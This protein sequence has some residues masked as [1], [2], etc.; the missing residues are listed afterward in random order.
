MEH[1]RQLGLGSSLLGFAPF[2]LLLAMIACLPLM[3]ATE[4]WWG[5]NRNKA[6]VAGLCA[7]VGILMYVHPTGDY[8]KLRDTLLEYLTFMALL[9]SLYVVCGGIHI[10]GA[11]AGLPYMNTLFLLVGALLA[12][13]MGTTG[14][15]MI[16]IRPLIRANRLRTRNAHVV[17]FFI[18]IVSNAGGLLTP[19]GD[20]PL[21]LGF[22]RGVP[23]AWTFRLF[24]HWGITL[25]LL[26]TIFHFIDEVIFHREEKDTKHF[27]VEEISKAERKVYVEGW[28][29]IFFLLALLG[30]IMA[31]GYLIQPTFSRL[32]GAEVG[33]A[34]SEIFQILAMIGIALMS[35]DLT[36]PRMYKA[37]GR[38]ITTYEK[39]EFS[40]S[41]MLEV[42]ILF[43][44]IFGSMLPTMAILQAKGPTLGVSEPWHF[45]W[46]SGI[47]SSFLDNA[48]TYLTFATLAA[49]KA[50]LSTH[51]L[52]EL[53]HQFPRLLE[54][55]ACGSVFMGANTYIGNGPNFMVKTIAEHS[56][57][58]MP[59]F[60][61]YML[62]SCSILIPLFLIETWLFFR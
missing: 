34:C 32:Y 1:F 9:S 16:L 44:G 41:A 52:S 35:Y 62:W 14:A 8:A 10:T 47:L 55:V 45:F 22:L 26:L 27:L 5:Q 38:I 11:F 50:G 17:I 2:A 43:F 53:A 60:F 61:G 51:N 56:K 48:P 29:N 7:L 42:G 37:K 23:F 36:A 40:M 57:V 19:L 33:Q 28:R 24:P 4:A 39:N 46:G 15:S 49:S 20:P 54:A 6:I 21:Y 13:I 3:K 58:K 31:S 12:N 59:S 18:F 25:L 30:V